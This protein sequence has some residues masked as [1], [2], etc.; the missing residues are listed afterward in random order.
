MTRVLFNHAARMLGGVVLTVTGL[1]PTS[2]AAHEGEAAKVPSGAKFSSAERQAEEGDLSGALASVLAIEPRISNASVGLRP[3]QDYALRLAARIIAR[4]ITPPL[5]GFP[6][7]EE[8][9]KWAYLQVRKQKEATPTPSLLTDFG[10][11]ASRI[12]SERSDAIKTLETLDAEGT[13]ASSFGYATLA[14]LRAETGRESARVVGAPLQALAA[15]MR[16]IAVVR[17]QK[18]AKGAKHCDQG[19]IAVAAQK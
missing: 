5:A 14:R 18:L 11:I 2:I 1:M 7:D 16:Q 17:C 13:M 10:E 15:G 12:P 4:S 9:I 19:L 8:Q 6:N 3:N